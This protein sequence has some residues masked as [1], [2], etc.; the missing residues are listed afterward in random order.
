[1]KRYA[2]FPGCASESTAKSTQHANEFVFGKIGVD[3]IEIKD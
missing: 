1:M 2:Y 3:L